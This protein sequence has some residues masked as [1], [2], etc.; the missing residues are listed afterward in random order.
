[1]HRWVRWMARRIRPGAAF[2]GVGMAGLM[3][4]AAAQN[5]IKAVSS[6]MQSG[7]EVVRIDFTHALTRP[8]TGFSVQRP[9]RIALRRIWWA[10]R[11][12]R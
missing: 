4:A 9:A 10:V 12:S 11:R 8:P 3:Q 2:L 1:M 5:A 6:S 7:T